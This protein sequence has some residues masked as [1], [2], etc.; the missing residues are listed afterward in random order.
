MFLYKKR[1]ERLRRH[2]FPPYP[3]LGEDAGKGGDDVRG[4]FKKLGVVLEGACKDSFRKARFVD[5]R[6]SLDK[7]SLYEFSRKR[8]SR[9]WR[10]WLYWEQLI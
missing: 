9:N 5:F 8:N 2:F 3:P 10:D 6:K 1:K 7:I 4:V